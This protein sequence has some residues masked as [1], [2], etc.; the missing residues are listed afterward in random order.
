MAVWLGFYN[1]LSP[2]IATMSRLLV[3]WTAS[4]Q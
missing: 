2:V 1:I 4:N 3:T